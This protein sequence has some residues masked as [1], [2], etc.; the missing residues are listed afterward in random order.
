MLQELSITKGLTLT[1]LR[2]FNRYERWQLESLHSLP[3]HLF[4]WVVRGQGRI[5]LEGQVRGYS[6]NNAVFVPAGSMHAFDMAPGAIGFALY[7]DADLDL[8]LPTD[9]LQLRINDASHQAQIASCLDTI[10]TEID[11]AHPDKEQA[12]YFHSG[13]FSVWLN[14]TSSY[15][16][17]QIPKMGK[18]ARLLQ[19]Y[20]RLIEQNLSTGYSVA[21]YADSLGVTTT[22][23]TRVC[24]QSC[25]KSAS[26]LLSDRQFYEARQNLRET[27]HPIKNIAMNL[28]FRS[29]AYFSRAFLNQTGKSPSEFRNMA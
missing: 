25:G 1:T 5:N 8:D 22:H 29:A 21:D 24:N 15:Y 4:L 7:I 19:S 17:S 3:R 16:R 12:L 2:S 11:S 26:A 27:H 28:G 18:S 20:C 23:L 9:A 13:L 14:R 6:A 10:Q